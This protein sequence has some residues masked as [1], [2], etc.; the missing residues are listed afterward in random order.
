MKAAAFALALAS[1]AVAQITPDI[2]P[3][4]ACTG[5]DPIW[6]LDLLGNTAQFRFA[7]RTIDLDVMAETPGQPGPWP[8]ALTLVGRGDTAIVL[9]RGPA[10][11][12]VDILTQH[13][14]L[15]VLFTGTCEAG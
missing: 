2:V 13:R 6:A 15:P 7:D 5:T 12:T 11:F 8:V 10:P 1:P 9:V 4:M 3:Q 14:D